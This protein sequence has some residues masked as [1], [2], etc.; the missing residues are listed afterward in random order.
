M[1]ELEMNICE[2]NLSGPSKKNL[3]NI[4]DSINNLKSNNNNNNCKL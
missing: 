3:I 2:N 1:K 4:N